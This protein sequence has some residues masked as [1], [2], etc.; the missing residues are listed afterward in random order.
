[1]S[2]VQLCA[3]G[4]AV[5]KV[6]AVLCNLLRC[7]TITY[8]TYAIENE[9]GCS[10][11]TIA[12]DSFWVRRNVPIFTRLPPSRDDTDCTFVPQRQPLLDDIVHAKAISPMASERSTKRR[13]MS[14]LESGAYVLRKVLEDIPLREEGHS[15]VSITCVEYWSRS[16]YRLPLGGFSLI[17]NR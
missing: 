12:V 2:K 1:M 10:L 11:D 15:P 9:H 8:S 7:A 16:A 13:K 17:T 4:G 5:G 14:P 3:M 6:V